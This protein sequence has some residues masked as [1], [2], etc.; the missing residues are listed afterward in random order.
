M[1]LLFT[2]ANGFI[3]KNV[4]PLLSR[5]SFEVKTFGTHSAD[6]IGDITK[7]IPLFEEQFDIIFH[8]AGKAHSI[9]KTKEEESLFYDV[10]YQGTKNLCQSLERKIPQV[11]IFIS[12]VAVYGKDIGKDI[13][14]SFPT[15]G[16]TPYAK[17]KIMAENFL[18][19]WCKKNKVR[20]FIFRPSLI[21]GPNA[22]GNLGDMIK[23]IKNKRYFNIGAGDAQKS[24]FW[25]EDFATL[26]EL[27]IGNNGGIYNVCDN[28]NPT[29]K[30]ISN[31]IAQI[32]NQES[33]GSI[34]YF[35]AKL[36]ALVGDLL[37]NK[38]PIN[39]NKLRKITESLTFSNK[40]VKNEL[41]FSPSNVI[42]KFQI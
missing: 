6:F 16:N 11:F 39:S 20:L 21:A 10:N 30:E 25:V 24:I 28:E 36:L 13:D 26:T 40:K 9:P 17:S 8:A 15:N 35:M 22:P 37:G 31:K 32:F 2:G 38:A 12:T 29:F 5:N 7:K 34:P 18:I 33:S 27:T 1:K 41:V 14:E 3:G 23:A 4:I 19:D 42:E